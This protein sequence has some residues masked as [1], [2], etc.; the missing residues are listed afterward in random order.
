M[1][2]NEE[3][4]PVSDTDEL[5]VA[6][7]RRVDRTRALDEFRPSNAPLSAAA[8]AR[9]MRMAA[10]THHVRDWAPRSTDSIDEMTPLLEGEAVEVPGQ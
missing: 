1:G 7:G 9:E 5:S 2:V 8:I 10:K 6:G 3:N 4:V